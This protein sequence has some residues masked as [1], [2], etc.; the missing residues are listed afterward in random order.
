MSLAFQ[1]CVYAAGSQNL[2]LR[3]K[4]EKPISILWMKLEVFKMDKKIKML[5]V[6]YT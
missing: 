1:S 6:G 5:C 2:F 3:V 4:N